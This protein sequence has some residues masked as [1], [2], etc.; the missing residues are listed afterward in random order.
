MISDDCQEF[1]FIDTKKTAVHQNLIIFLNRLM[2][3]SFYFWKD[4]ENRIIIILRPIIVGIF[5]ENI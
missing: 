2:L 1:V 4:D 3:I 5:F